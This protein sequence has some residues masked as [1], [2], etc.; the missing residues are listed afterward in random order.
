MDAV[1]VRRHRERVGARRGHREQV[2]ATRRGERDVV[3]EDVAR[4]AVHPRD[5]DDLVDGLA[6]ARRRERGVARVVQ[7][8]ARVVRHAAVDRDPGPLRQPLHAADPVERHPCPPDEGAPGLEPDLGLRQAGLD[9]GEAH[10]GRSARGELRGVRHL[11]GGMVAD[12]EPA[13]EVGDLRRP[14]ELVAAA[15]GEGREAHDRLGLR[16]E[17]R[18]LRA[19]VDM[20]AEHVEAPLERLRDDGTGLIGREP[21]L[22]AVVPRADRLVR[23]GVDAERDPHERALDAGG[24]GEAGLVP[25]VEHDRCADLRRLRQEGLVLV[26]AVDDEVAATEARG[27]RERELAGGGDVRAD[28]RPRAAGGAGRRWGAPSSRRRPAR[29]RRPTGARA[30][31][32]AASPRRGRRGASRATRRAPPR[33]PRRASARRRRGPPIAGRALA[34]VDRAC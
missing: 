1:V 6:G 19:D 30:P 31:A 10:G 34:P 7:L 14:A 15:R 29:R 8:R 2:A 4:L 11:V 27:T 22:R 18:E 5:A 9:E 28:P 21:E 12:P 24:R 13:A 33:R 16:V 17:V 20:D 3:D 25:R 32:R 26:V 23:V